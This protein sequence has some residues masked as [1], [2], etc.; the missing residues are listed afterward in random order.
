MQVEK[1]DDFTVRLTFADPYPVI[2]IPLAHYRGTMGGGL[3]M[4]KHYCQQFHPAYQDADKL[5][6][7]VE[8]GGFE[9]W[10]QL[11]REK[12]R[13]GSTL[14]AAVGLL[15]LPAFHRVDDKPEFH[16]YE[17]DPYFWKV[18]SAGNQ[19]PYI[20]QVRVDI[21]QD[22]EVVE[23]RLV[24]GEI[25]MAGR[26][27]QIKNVDLYKANEDAG[28]FRLMFWGSVFGSRIVFMPNHTSKNPDLWAFFQN[29]NVC[30][31]MSLTMNR[32]DINDTIFFGIGKPRQVTVIRKSKY[33]VEEYAQQA[34]ADYDPDKA[35]AC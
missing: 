24:A 15:T 14:P 9:R 35:T 17:R 25:T 27:A 3:L 11:F 16:F 22:R 32:E 28:D 4:S 6:E 26:M 19:L 30:I 5:Q 7:M 8:E 1:I 21:V 29:R 12:C 13:T 34:Y 31:A 10:D 18:D 20:D 23:R 2:V 33:F